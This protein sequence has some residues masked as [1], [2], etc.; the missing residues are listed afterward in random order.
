MVTPAI[1]WALLLTWIAALISC[2]AA[3]VTTA[4]VAAET[5]R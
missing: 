1:A 4:E 3:S 2:S 5:G